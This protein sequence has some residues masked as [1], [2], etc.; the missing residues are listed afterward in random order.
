MLSR[1]RAS[2]RLRRLVPV[3]KRFWRQATFWPLYARRKTRFSALGVAAGAMPAAALLHLEADCA[4]VMQSSFVALTWNNIC[5]FGRAGRRSALQQRLSPTAA[6]ISLNDFPDFDAWRIGVSRATQGKYHRS[7]NKAR[8]LG[9]VSRMVGLHSHRRSI[10]ELVG[11]KVRRSKGLFVWEA[12]MRPPA[13]FQDTGEPARAPVCPRH[14]RQCWAGFRVTDEGEKLTAFAI[15]IRA[16][17]LLWVQRFVGHGEA[18]TDGVTKMLIFDIMQYVLARD[19]PDTRGI[20]YLLHGYVEEGGAGLFNWKRYLG[21][22]PMYLDVR[23]ATRIK[24][25]HD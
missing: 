24:G 12:L 4:C 16:G 15:F 22:K 11:S 23:A 2:P 10:Y 5:E 1:L 7:A 14:W 9:Y 19:T 18:L 17:N 21:F 8:R 20:D 13:D 6:V 3:V 25:D